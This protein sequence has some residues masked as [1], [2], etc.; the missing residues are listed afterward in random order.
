[1]AKVV[2]SATIYLESL[3]NNYH[4]MM[5][6]LNEFLFGDP[7]I[8]VLLISGLPASG[9]TAFINI[10][11]TYMDNV[12]EVND[13]RLIFNYN[14]SINRF[15]APEHF[16]L[17]HHRNRDPEDISLTA[18]DVITLDTVGDLECIVKLSYEVPFNKIYKYPKSQR[19]IIIGCGNTT[20]HD[21]VSRRIIHLKFDNQFD[22]NDK[23]NN[24][25]VKY[26][27]EHYGAE[28]VDKI[29]NNT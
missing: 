23:N 22:Y 19:I 21:S 28:I 7:D 29:K 18:I 17:E 1:M 8:R 25:Y 27:T 15:F 6:T 3:T 14:R 10:L 5:K 11:K 2:N 12:N 9:K 20:I 16:I 4:Y 26:I 13:Y 24:Q